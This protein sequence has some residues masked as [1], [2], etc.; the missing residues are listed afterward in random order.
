MGVEEFIE[1]YAKIE[2]L[3]MSKSGQLE[4][5]TALSADNVS[6]GGRSAS[7][8]WGKTSKGFMER[9]ALSMAK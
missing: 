5:T 9:P 8:S 3:K 6:R 1:Q 2:L 4:E 7:R